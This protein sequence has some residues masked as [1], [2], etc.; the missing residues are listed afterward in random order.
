MPNRI[1]VNRGVYILE[2]FAEY[3]FTI[4]SQTFGKVKL[5]KGY[6]YY[7]GSAQ[8]NL[9]SRIQRHLKKEKIVHWHIDLIT[10]APETRITKICVLPFA[11]KSVEC[12]T[13]QKMLK[14]KFA[15][16]SIP[17]F[18]N[19][20]CNICLTHLLYSPKRLS[21][22]QFSFLYQSIVCLIPSSSDIS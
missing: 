4:K 9:R 10:T 2:I 8:K 7:V 14:F 1:E 15:V 12:E 19:S 20:D 11:P 18:G 17:H 6:Y 21:Q 5:S 16:N 3:D 22:S 13:V